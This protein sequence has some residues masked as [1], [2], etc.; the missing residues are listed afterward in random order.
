VATFL[1]IGLFRLEE[2]AD[3]SNPV[4]KRDCFQVEFRIQKWRDTMSEIGGF[5][6]QYV[7]H[8]NG[9]PSRLRSQVRLQV[10]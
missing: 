10:S 9:Y 1:D 2:A 3:P 7:G 4:P 5:R 8:A 6:E